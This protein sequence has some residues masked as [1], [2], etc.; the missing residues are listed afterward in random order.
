MSLRGISG[1]VLGYSRLAQVGKVSLFSDFTRS[2]PTACLREVYKACSLYI[3]CI[4]ITACIREV[5]KACSLYIV[6]INIRACI[7]EIYKACS[8][9]IVCINITACIREVYKACSL[10][11]VCINITAC[12]REVYK[13][14]SLYIVCIYIRS[15]SVDRTYLSTP[16]CAGVY[17]GGPG[18]T[19]TCQEEILKF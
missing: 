11:I 16:G 17:R 13:A 15:S 12:L 19:G 8:L 2:R 4:N 9:Y 1:V 7:R 18:S 10:Y 3:V 14:C 6:C 5:Y